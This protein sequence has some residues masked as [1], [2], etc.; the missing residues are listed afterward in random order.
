MPAVTAAGPGAWERDGRTPRLEPLWRAGGLRASEELA[1]PVGLAVSTEGRAAVTDFSLSEVV[2]IE[3]DGRWAGSWARRGEGPGELSTPVA[4]TWDGN[5]HLIVYDLTASKVLF[6]DGEGPVR[7]D[8]PVS[9]AIASAILLTGELPW[10]GV[11]P[12][13]GIVLQPPLRVATD[14]EA[15]AVVVRYDPGAELPDTVGRSMLPSAALVQGSPAPGWPRLSPSLGAGGSIGLAGST[16]AYRIT[17]HDAGGQPE[18][19]ICRD[20]TA[21][22]L[23]PWERGD[24]VPAD[25]PDDLLAELRA[26]PRPDALSAVGRIFL[27]VDGRLW[28]QRERASFPRGDFLGVPGAAYDVFDAD[29]AFQGTVR[30]PDDVRLQGA[31]GDTVYGFATGTYDETEVVAYRLIIE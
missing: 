4:A 23:S 10:V 5:G 16:A 8:L 7:E 24:S 11:Q 14:G 9:T 30:V 28:V 31:L 22:P 3:P 17:L 12:D 18:R 1:Y 15:E 27:S 19:V 6:L 13:G 29:G 25:F 2:V 26:S 21:L 20:A